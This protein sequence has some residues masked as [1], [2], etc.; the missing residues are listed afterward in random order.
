MKITASIVTFN[1]GKEVINLLSSIEKTILNLCDV[2]VI[3]NAS[4]DDTVNLIRANFKD[5]NVIELDH[6]LGYGGGH[7]VAIRIVKSDYHAIINPDI[8]LSENCISDMVDYME[9]NPNTVILTPKVLNMDG[10]EQFLPKKIPTYRF[11]ISGRLPFKSAKKT[12]SIYTME[13]KKP[14]SPTDIDFCT[15]CFMFCRTSTLKTV[16]GFDERYFM[17]F[18]DADLTREMQKIGKTT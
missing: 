17:Y 8:L 5:V 1:S 13:D 6:N 4:T 15:G 2:Y 18:E 9:S 7:N 11:L 16:G 3:D 12:R 10:S 14:T